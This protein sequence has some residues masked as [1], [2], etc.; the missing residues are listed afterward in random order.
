MEGLKLVILVSFESLMGVYYLFYLSILTLI[1]LT[2][3]SVYH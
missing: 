1:L 2:S 3:N